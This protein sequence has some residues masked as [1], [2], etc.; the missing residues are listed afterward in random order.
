MQFSPDIEFTKNQAYHAAAILFF[1]H[2]ELPDKFPQLKDSLHAGWMACFKHPMSYEEL[3]RPPSVGES[4]YNEDELNWC[5]ATSQ[6]LIDSLDPAGRLALGIPESAVKRRGPSRP[7]RTAANVA[8][9]APTTTGA[10]PRGRGGAGGAASSR[11]GG[12]QMSTSGWASCSN[13]ADGADAA[14]ED[15]DGNITKADNETMENT[16]NNRRRASRSKSRYP[17][18]LSFFLVHVLY[19]AYLDY[20]V[21]LAYIG[22]ICTL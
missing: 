14:E 17:L 13:D 21:K 12:K 3:L 7:G 4:A 22:R 11:G 10:R 20:I 16:K 9:L 1:H 2:P 8:G 19:L 15:A 5:M 18:F 6:F